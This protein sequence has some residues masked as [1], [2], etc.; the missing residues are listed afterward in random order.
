M[1]P[2]EYLK[3]F[4]FADCANC[5]CIIKYYCVHLFALNPWCILKWFQSADTVGRDHTDPPQK[6]KCI[7][8]YSVW[9]LLLCA[10]CYV[11]FF[12]LCF[13]FV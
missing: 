10:N 12:L 1:L 3:S 6:R 7:F 9:S 11:M 5:V 13:F 4:S 2:D 8:H